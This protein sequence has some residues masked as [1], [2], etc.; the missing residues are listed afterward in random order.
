VVLAK[1][2]ALK[3]H[4]DSPV[5]SKF[6]EDWIP[7]LSKLKKALTAEWRARF[8]DLS[9]ES[10]PTICSDRMGQVYRSAGIATRTAI[11]A[12]IQAA[13]SRELV[14]EALAPSS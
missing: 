4:D 12:E 10:T 7:E 13:D 6:G 14:Q 8:K 1:V 11:G 9:S 5:E 2:D 3:N